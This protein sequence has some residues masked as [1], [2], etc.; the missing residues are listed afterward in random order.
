MNK[1]E[2]LFF[3]AQF[4][5]WAKQLIVYAMIGRIIMSWLSMGQR[6]PT[7]KLAHFLY[8]VT[9]P[10]LNIARKIPHR[11]GMIDIAPIIA[12]LGIELI[13]SLIIQLITGMA[14]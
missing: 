1:V 7:G 6:R 3:T 12:I 11:I 9:E 10:F 14:I 8:D 2:L 13:A 5:Y 4:V